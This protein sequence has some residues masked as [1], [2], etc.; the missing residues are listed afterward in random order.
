MK[1]H[2]KVIVVTGGGNGMGRELVLNLLSKGAFVAA[3]DINE[4]ALEETAQLAGELKK[5]LM[6]VPL[7][8]TN[9]E[10]VEAL[11]GK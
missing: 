3:V 2:N 7:N 5:D 10:A 9:K 4:K 6:T 1:V 11:P 8:I